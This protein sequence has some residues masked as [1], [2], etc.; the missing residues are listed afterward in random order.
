MEIDRK[1]Q[2]FR[3][4]QNRPEETV[5]EIAPAM[6]AVDDDALE[7]TI[8]ERALELGDRG[9]RIADRQ[10]RKPEEAG[11]MAPDRSARETHSSRARS[12]FASSASS[13][14]TPG[15]VSESACTSTPRCVHRRDPAV[16]DIGE[17]SE[18]RRQPAASPLRPLLEVAV[19]TVEK[20]GRGEVFFE[21]DR[22][23]PCALL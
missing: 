3:A 12:R 19:R 5:V 17:L 9:R 22:A 21:G 2:R 10:R 15:A 18:H 14:S 1:L 7:A 11:R 8:A 23:H 20:G 6:M 16:A 13:C 4:R